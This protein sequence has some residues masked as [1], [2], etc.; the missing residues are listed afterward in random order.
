MSRRES[1]K[2]ARPRG[3]EVRDGG[4]KSIG[5]ASGADACGRAFPPI[6]A[7]VAQRPRIRPWRRQDMVPAAG[8]LAPEGMEM[9][10]KEELAAASFEGQSAARMNRRR[11]GLRANRGF[12]NMRVPSG[13]RR[14]VMRVS[15]KGYCRQALKE[16]KTRKNGCRLRGLS[17]R[18][19]PSAWKTVPRLPVAG[20][21]RFGPGEP[22]YGAFV[23]KRHGDSRQSP[24]SWTLMVH[25]TRVDVTGLT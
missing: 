7:Y 4:S 17:R 18:P 10:S 11:F 6:P 19:F 16:L 13:E 25:R 8:T 9:V 20:K 12:P 21:V 5:R 2:M 14:A 23:P 3:M 1:R 22:S 24:N 15:R